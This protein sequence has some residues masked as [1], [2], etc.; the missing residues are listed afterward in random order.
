MDSADRSPSHP[1]TSA[2]HRAGRP[3]KTEGPRVNYAELDQLIVFGEPGTEPGEPVRYPS[4]RELAARYGVAVSVIGDYGRKHKCQKRRKA[5]ARRIRALVDQ[6]LAELH[7]GA[8]VSGA[9]RGPSAAVLRDA[10]SDV[11]VEMNAPAI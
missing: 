1:S 4:Y 8:K 9:P 6:K 2:R 5:A 10:H 3:R 11:L 7:A